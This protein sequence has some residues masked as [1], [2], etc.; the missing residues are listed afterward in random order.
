M[1][2]AGAVPMQPGKDPVTVERDPLNVAQDVV[3]EL[4]LREVAAAIQEQMTVLTRSADTLTRAIQQRG[5][6]RIAAAPAEGCV[7]ADPSG[8]RVANR[9][10][11]SDSG[12]SQADS[13]CEL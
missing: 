2:V 6:A 4:A 8:Q 7:G 1:G 5:S 3:L 10:P 9:R 13:M 11:G 12:K